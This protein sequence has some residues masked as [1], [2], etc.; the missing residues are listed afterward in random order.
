MTKVETII[1]KLTNL[2]LLETTL[3]TLAILLIINIIYNYFDGNKNIIEGFEQKQTFLLKTDEEIYDDFYVSMY[4]ILEYNK[5]HNQ[6][7]IGNIIDTT[8]PNEKSIILEVGSNTGHQV[9]QL[10]NLTKNVIGIDNSPSMVNKA[11]KN[12]PNLN[13]MN[14]DI[15]NNVLFNANHF[16]HILCLGKQL[17]YI[18]NKKMFLENCYN[19]LMPGGY[20]SLRLMDNNSIK[21]LDTIRNIKRNTLPS[22]V[23]PELLLD[24]SIKFKEFTYK[25]D[26]E[27]VSESI[28]IF[29]ETFKYNNGNVRQNEHKLYMQDKKTIIKMAQYIGFIVLKVYDMQECECK[30]AKNYT[31]ILQKP[32]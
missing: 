19:W 26:F 3:Y 8:G 9:R 7:E 30:C 31:Y 6:F 4:D 28:S 23:D 24:S 17:Y 25:P 14:E 12:Y 1:K 11:L 27:E 16:T 22:F 2:S 21:P 20:L 29:K 32:N 10:A 5:I 18:Q 15:L 13:F